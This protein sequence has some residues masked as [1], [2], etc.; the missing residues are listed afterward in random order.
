MFAHL[1]VDHAGLGPSDGALANALNAASLRAVSFPFGHAA[2]V[3]VADALPMLVDRATFVIAD[4]QKSARQAFDDQ[5]LER[6]IPVDV[7]LGRPSPAGLHQEDALVIVLSVAVETAV[8]AR[9]SLLH[10][11]FHA[12][13]TDPSPQLVAQESKTHPMESGHD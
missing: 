10:Q 12:A 11:L 6:V 4:R 5:T 1:V 9:H 13:R 3:T 7:D 2:V 8:A